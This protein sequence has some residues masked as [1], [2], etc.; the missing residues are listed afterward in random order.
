MKRSKIADWALLLFNVVLVVAI[1][2][3]QKQ[4]VEKPTLLPIQPRMMW[5][6]VLA[7]MGLFLS[8]SSGI[9][10]GTLS[11]RSGLTAD[12]LC[13]QVEFLYQSTSWCES[14]LLPGHLTPR[15]YHR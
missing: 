6:I 1:D 9:G 7:G 4:D 5:G 11:V 12:L 10:G 14:A 13:F 2:K 15:W 8:A 3:F